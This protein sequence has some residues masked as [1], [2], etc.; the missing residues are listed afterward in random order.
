MA[1][2]SQR[3]SDAFFLLGLQP[4][5][6]ALSQLSE[7]DQIVYNI[8]SSNLSIDSA[9]QVIQESSASGNPQDIIPGR[10]RTQGNIVLNLRGNNYQRLLQHALWCETPTKTQKSGSDGWTGKSGS[11]QSSV[12]TL[13]SSSSIGSTGAFLTA[14]GSTKISDAEGF[15]PARLEFSL[16]SGWAFEHSNDAA[17]I[18]VVG[19]DMDSISLREDIYLALDG[20]SNLTVNGVAVSPSVAEGGV[21]SIYTRNYFRDYSTVTL[22]KTATPNTAEKGIAGTLAIKAVNNRK[23]IV[24]LPD[25]DPLLATL[26]L[27][28]GEKAPF[29]YDQLMANEFRITQQGEGNPQLEIVYQGRS[30]NKGG[31]APWG[32]NGR[33]GPA[34]RGLPAGFKEVDDSVMPYYGSTIE[35]DNKILPMRNAT[36]DINHNYDVLNYSTRDRYNAPPEE[37][38]R[39]TARLTGTVKYEYDE[40]FTEDYVQSIA[41]DD[42]SL[43]FSRFPSGQPYTRMFFEFGR[44]KVA[45]TPGKAIGQGVIEQDI[46]IILLGTKGAVVPDYL[47]LVLWG[48]EDLY[49]SRFTP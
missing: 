29:I 25:R 7:V 19:A 3:G 2:I 22:R 23:E 37:Q 41:V 28:F 49:G 45:A 44:G 6:A 48:T 39:I 46:E 20:S 4:G 27:Q 14:P 24:M 34:V 32:I 1:P 38:S 8:L 43:S 10:L 30:E 16:G 35:F 21:V 13:R 15:E 9:P 36:L 18:T 47:K 42:F 40:S 5:D 11:V 33:S 26:E 31:L 17:V 12:K